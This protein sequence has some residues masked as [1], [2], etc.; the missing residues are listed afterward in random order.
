MPP[1]PVHPRP[2]RIAP[3]S[4]RARTSG[5][6]ESSHSQPQG[7]TPVSPTQAPVGGSPQALSPGS[8]F[9]RPLF[10]YGSIACNVDCS[11]KSFH[12]ENYYDISGFAALSELRDSMCLVQRYSLK[13]FMVLRQY[14][15]PRVVIE[16]YQT[17]TSRR[18]RH[19]TIL[20]FSIDDGEGILRASDIAATFNLPMALAN[21]ANYR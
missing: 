5:P 6:R 20:H 1:L 4:K 21:S 9:R 2:R 7:L 13:P 16:S 8:L 3:P 15:Y 11:T 12:N 17:M 10:Y 19:S 18:E 14:F